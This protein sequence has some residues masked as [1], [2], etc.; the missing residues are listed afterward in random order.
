[1]SATPLASFDLAEALYWRAVLAERISE[2]ERDWKR[3]VIEAPLSLRTPD[4]LLRLGELDMLRG[5]PSDARPY[6]ERVVREFPDSTRIARGTIWLVRSYFDDYDLW[7]TPTAQTL[8]FDASL[9]YP[10]EVAG[11]TMP[12]YLGWMRSVC[13][14]SAMDVPAISV[15]AGFSAEGLPV[16][17][18]IVA[19]HGGDA[20][21]LRAAR[22]LEE[23]IGAGR[24]PP[25]FGAE[26]RA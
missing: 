18:Q 7:I 24:V 16:G 19:P 3:L 23:L 6:F 12:D 4:A 14:V 21:L 9:R 13:V 10:S 1:V 26:E 2:A 11:V 25:R 22:A 5:H 17:V 15:P 20:L 8:P